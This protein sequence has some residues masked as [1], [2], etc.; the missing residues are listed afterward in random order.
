MNPRIFD[1]VAIPTIVIIQEPAL[2]IN[3]FISPLFNKAYWLKYHPGKTLD[4]IQQ[5]QPDLIILKLDKTK[6]NCSN[7][8]T[9]LK[10]DWLTR[11]IPILVIGNKFILQSTANLGYDACLKTPYSIKELERAICSLV[12]TPACHSLA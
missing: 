9:S 11:D 3:S 6:E 7:L 4:W 12:S 2:R 8:I 1:G 5:N 10:L